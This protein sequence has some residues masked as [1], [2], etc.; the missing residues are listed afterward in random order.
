LAILAVR[1][2]FSDAITMRSGHLLGQNPFQELA[3]R[4][5]GAPIFELPH[6]GCYVIHNL[7]LKFS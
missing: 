1:A 2:V 3:E 5:L 7:R 6:I 4:V